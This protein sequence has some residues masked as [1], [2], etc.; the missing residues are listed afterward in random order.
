MALLTKE[1]ILA[2]D[3]KEEVV[4]VPEWGGE[5]RVRA[6]MACERDEY[7]SSLVTTKVVDDKTETQENFKNAKA[8]LVVKCVL[9]ADGKR[10][11]TD[12]DA[13]AL[14]GKLAGVIDRLFQKIQDLSGMSRKAQKVAEKNSVTDQT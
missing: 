5:V 6:C 14:G 11:F 1:Q 9:D 13:D 12:A 4:P 3:L 7:E 10:M 2:T 8:R